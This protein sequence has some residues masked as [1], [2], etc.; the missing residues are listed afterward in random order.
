MKQFKFVD[1]VC[2]PTRVTMYSSSQI[3]VLMTTDVQCFE[4]TKVFPFSGSDHHLIVS[5]FYSRGV[6]VDPPSHRFVVVR[7]FQKLDTAKLDEL[8]ACDDIWD[9]VL[10]TYDDISECLECFNLIMNGLLDL[11]VPLKKLRV[12]QRDCPWLAI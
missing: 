3:D 8:L 2:A 4:F 10:S 9:A 11:L 6:C 7:N 12:R 1:L 5:H